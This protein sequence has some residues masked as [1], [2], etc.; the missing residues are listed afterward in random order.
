MV[1][2][3][4]LGTQQASLRLCHSPPANKEIRR[5]SGDLARLG[6]SG[7]PSP[8]LTL[9]APPCPLSHP[10]H[11]VHECQQVL[12]YMLLP[13]ELHHRVIHAQQDLDVVVVVRSMPACPPPRAVGVLL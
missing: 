6:L 4:H 7:L 13:V 11:N 2:L 8:W 12:L 1:N 3:S 9:P 5:A 10:T